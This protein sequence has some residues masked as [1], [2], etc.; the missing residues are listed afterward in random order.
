M[1]GKTMNYYRSHEYVKNKT[2]EK[3]NIHPF[4]KLA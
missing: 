2:P 4:K 1:D 3:T